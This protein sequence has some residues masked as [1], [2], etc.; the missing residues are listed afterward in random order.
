MWEQPFIHGTKLV[1]G[2]WWGGGGGMYI[3]YVYM[4][5]SNNDDKKMCTCVHK[6]WWCTYVRE[7]TI[8][9]ICKTTI[10]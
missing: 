9:Y 6:I 4:W 1:V 3:K 7:N 2:F 8:V 5:T 10:N